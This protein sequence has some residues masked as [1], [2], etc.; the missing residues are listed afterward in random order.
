MSEL[1]NQVLSVLPG[2]LTTDIAQSIQSHFGMPGL[3][4]TLVLGLTAAILIFIKLLRI[5]FDIVR[6]VAI[7]SLAVA[8]LASCFLPYPFAAILPVVVVFFS[9]GLIFKA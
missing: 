1:V 5:A 2:G 7:P 8:F 3:A 9:L 4:A 6:F